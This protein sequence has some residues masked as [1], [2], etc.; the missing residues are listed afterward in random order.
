[1]ADKL[2]KKENLDKLVR[3][4]NAAGGRVVA[5]TIVARQVVYKAINGA[6]EITFDY[7]LPRNSY[8]EF[9]FP[10]T[11]V[12]ADFKINKEGVEL[13]SRDVNPVETVVFGARPCEAA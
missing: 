12:I 8:K 1:M 11:E 3:S 13:S 6:D 5:P 2:L 7:I 10:Q 4:V 9:L